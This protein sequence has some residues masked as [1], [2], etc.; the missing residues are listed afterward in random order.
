MNN[1]FIEHRRGGV[2]V[3][4]REMHN[5]WTYF[6]KQY[7]SQLVSYQAIDSIGGDVPQTSYRVRYLGLGIGGCEAASVAYESAFLSAY[8]PGED[9]NATAGN[10]YNKIDPTSPVISTLER[11]VRVSGGATPY[12]GSAGDVWLFGPPNF[13]AHYRDTN[14]VTFETTV[15]CTTGALVYGTFSF[16]P[17]SEAGLFH[18]GASPGTAYN[19][20]IAYINFATITLR[21]DSVIKFYW[22]MRLAS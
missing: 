14:S 6:G 11:P 19:S 13:S 4:I 2:L 8:P 16:M 17:I 10:V 20:A 7:L 21:S 18:A 5:V 12:P 1:V 9:P 15:D 3:E 22:T